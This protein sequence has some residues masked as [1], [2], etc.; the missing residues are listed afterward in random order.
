MMRTTTTKW[1]LP[2][3]KGQT[4]PTQYIHHAHHEGNTVNKPNQPPTK[5][6]VMKGSQPI[7][8]AMKKTGYYSV[9]FFD[10]MQ[11]RLMTFEE[12]TRKRYKLR[13]M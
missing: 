5:F 10:T 9:V 1:Q 8:E 12:I 6:F 13:A 7:G 4:S 11:G 2:L 3:Q